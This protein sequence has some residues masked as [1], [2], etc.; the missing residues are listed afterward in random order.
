MSADNDF[1]LDKKNF[2]NLPAFIDQVLHPLGMRFVPMF[3]CAISAGEPPNSY[4]PFAEGESMSVFVRNHDDQVFKGKVW[5]RVSSVWPDFT[6][7][8]ATAYWTN[9]FLSY[10]KEVAYDGAWIDMNEPSNFWDGEARGCPVSDRL[11]EPPYVPGMVNENLTLRH[12]TLCMTAKQSLGRHYDLHNLYGLTEAIV[13]NRFESSS[14]D[15]L[16][17]KTIISIS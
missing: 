8:N 7:Q 3:D 17:S 4:P 12:K 5:N 1:T 9:Q 10:H 11:E 2:Q 13:T 6:H 14:F 16:K 15:R